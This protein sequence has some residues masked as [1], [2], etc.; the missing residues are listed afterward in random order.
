MLYS[1][2]KYLAF[3]KNFIIPFRIY[4]AD[5]SFHLFENMLKSII[6]LSTMLF[7]N[8]R[9]SLSQEELKKLTCDA[10]KL[11]FETPVPLYF[12]AQ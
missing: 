9:I 4:D 6:C 10:E 3:L 7:V 8:N 12:R 1:N 11:R 5:T 2:K